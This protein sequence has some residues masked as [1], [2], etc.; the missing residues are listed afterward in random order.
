MKEITTTI[1]Q[2]GQVTIPTEVRLAPASFS[3][4]SAY[5]S[6][7]PSREPEDFDEISRIAK[8]S[9]A[10]S[11]AT[12]RISTMSQDSIESNLDICSS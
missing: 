8:E 1:T 4:E 9:K 12:T 2:R 7:K 6:V 5:G 10:E 11:S 3:L